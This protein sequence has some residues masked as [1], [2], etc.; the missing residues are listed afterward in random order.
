MKINHGSRQTNMTETLLHIQ[1]TLAILKQVACCTVTQGVNGD[2]MIEA[3][4]CQGVLH[5][6]AYIS[7]LDRLRSYSFAMRLENKVVT[8]IPLLEALQHFDLLFRDGYAAVL[9]A[10]ALIDK[11]LLTVKTYINPLEAACLAYS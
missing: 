6:G 8:G 1:Q 4:L 3:G 10:F 2:R 11:N 9:L 5:N 7:R